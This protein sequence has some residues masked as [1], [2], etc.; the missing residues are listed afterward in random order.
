MRAPGS[1]DAGHREAAEGLRE[2]STGA[3][4]VKPTDDLHRRLLALLADQ[5]V[6]HRLA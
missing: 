2:R 4:R 5:K 3:V 1:L 6:D